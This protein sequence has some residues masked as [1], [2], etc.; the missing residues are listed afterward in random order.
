MAEFTDSVNILRDGLWQEMSTSDL[1]P[2]DVFEVAEGKTTPCDAVVLTGNIVVDESSL[3]GEPL[4][5]RKFPL[6]VDDDS[7]YERMGA[8]KISTIFC[9]TTISQAQPT[10]QGGRVTALVTQTGTATDK[11]ELIKKILFPTPVSFIFNEQLKIVILILL[12]CGVLCLG[13]AIWLYAKGT[14]KW[15]VKGEEKERWTYC[16]LCAF[17]L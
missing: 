9:G 10:E 4:P 8:G 6:R 12:C 16:M 15:P 13:L 11:G 7:K 14:S 17:S 2:G 3:T 5:I 1:V